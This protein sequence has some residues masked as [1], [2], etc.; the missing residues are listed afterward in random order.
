MRADT[1]R[2]PLRL[3][4]GELLS[5]IPLTDLAR[6]LHEER[7]ASSLRFR[8]LTFLNIMLRRRDFSDNTWMYV[9]NPELKMSRIQ[10]PKRRSAWMAPDGRTSIMIEIPCDVGDDVWRADARELSFRMSAELAR[11]GFHADDAL[12][13]FVVRVEHGYPIY[14]LGYERDRQELLAAVARFSNVRTAGRQGLFRYVFM[15][16]AMQMGLEAA[17]QMMRGERQ[18]ASIDA[19]GRSFVPLETTAITA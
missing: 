7:S 11:L 8:A 16:A 18:G 2:G 1:S 5:T 13:A 4:V 17:R 12:G 14:H 3:P 9:A 15:D 10:E 19:I 6:A